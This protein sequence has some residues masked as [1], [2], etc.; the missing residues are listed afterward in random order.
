MGLQYYGP[1][2]DHTTYERV[3]RAAKQLAPAPVYASVCAD[4][5][6]PPAHPGDG[7]RIRPV[8]DQPGAAGEAVR[9]GMATLRSAGVRLLH[10]THS[11]LA[12]WPNGTEYKCCH[13]CEDLTY[14]QS[15]AGEEARRWPSDG[16]FTDNAVANDAWLPYY[17]AIAEVARREKPNRWFALNEDCA[18]PEAWGECSPVC[19]QFGHSAA[20]CANCRA[21]SRCS[22][23][24]KEW[25]DLADV[26]LLSEGTAGSREGADPDFIMHLP[27]E[28]TDAHK[29]KFSMFTYNATAQSWRGYIDRARAQGFSKF[30]VTDVVT[31]EFLTLPPW[32]E[33]MVEYI[34]GFNQEGDLRLRGDLEAVKVGAE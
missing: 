21:G 11:R 25:M 27:F 5:G 29:N 18:F 26:H 32:F 30:Y 24:T 6:V 13:C 10:Y 12:E 33:E 15:R 16:V 3:A 4:H 1:P 28:P 17:Q 20:Q 9:R 34:H 14:V 23:L 19:E 31:S 7:G 2:I 8:C 22:T